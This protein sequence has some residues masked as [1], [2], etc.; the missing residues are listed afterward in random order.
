M[1][2]TSKQ[3]IR[4]YGFKKHFRGLIT[5]C[6]REGIYTAGYLGIGP[7]ITRKL[8]E[9]YNYSRTT[10]KIIGFSIGGGSYQ[11]HLH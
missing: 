5:S 10:N 3:I 8:E 1:I 4:K 2:N 7:V 9:N 11:L 6:G